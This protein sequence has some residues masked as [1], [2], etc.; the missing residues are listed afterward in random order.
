[1]STPQNQPAYKHSF[2]RTMNAT[3]SRGLVFA[4]D[5]KN[6]KYTEETLQDATQQAAQQAPVAKFHRNINVENSKGVWWGLKDEDDKG[7]FN[8]S[9]KISFSKE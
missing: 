3:E 9:E 5:D 8:Y 7:K 6:V 1:M 2:E 4:S